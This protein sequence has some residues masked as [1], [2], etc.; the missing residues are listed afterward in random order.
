MVG[1]R[2]VPDSSV[3]GELDVIERSKVMR[4]MRSYCQGLV[5]V[6]YNMKDSALILTGTFT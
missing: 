3:S 1:V 6:Y 4:L 2:L 5:W